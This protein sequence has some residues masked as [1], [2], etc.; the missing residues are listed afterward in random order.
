MCRFLKK[1]VEH[2]MLFKLLFA[3]STFI[4]VAFLIG[5]IFYIQE[6]Q[7][8]NKRQNEYL[9]AN[10]VTNNINFENLLKTVTTD[11]EVLTA[12]KEIL[13][14]SKLNRNELQQQNFEEMQEFLSTYVKSRFAFDQ[15]SYYFENSE[16]LVGMDEDFFCVNQGKNIW[17]HL[18][19]TEDTGKRLVESDSALFTSKEKHNALLISS[20]VS[21]SCIAIRRM[22]NSCR[23]CWLYQHTNNDSGI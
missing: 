8:S 17:E 20:R 23:K 7:Q 16:S 11:K 10:L 5:L 18:E 21:D 19:V 13:R 9:T 1:L 2:Q 15:I 22:P 3:F 12:S 6:A 14:L 4:V